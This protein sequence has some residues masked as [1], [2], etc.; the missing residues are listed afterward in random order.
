VAFLAITGLFLRT[1][2]F[3]RIDKQSCPYRRRLLDFAR[4]WILRFRWRG[5][6][7]GDLIIIRVIIIRI[8]IV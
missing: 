5:I 2:A 6:I 1:L 3:S 7:S 8:V 4:R